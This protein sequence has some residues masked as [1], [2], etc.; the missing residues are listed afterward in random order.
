MVAQKACEPFVGFP[1]NLMLVIIRA[2]K[3]LH[4]TVLHIELI[5]IQTWANISYKRV[6]EAI[7]IMTVIKNTSTL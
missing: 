1:T 2:L 5:L 3:L 6:T 7:D 4:I